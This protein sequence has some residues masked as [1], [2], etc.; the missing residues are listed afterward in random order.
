MTLPLVK[1]DSWVLDILVDPLDKSRLR[2]MEGYD[3]VWLSEYGRVY[4]AIDGV[5]DLRVL[6]TDTTQSA[7]IWRKGQAAYETW[8]A[9]MAVNDDYDTYIREIEGVREVYEAL[10]ITGVC[11][12]VGGHQGRVRYFLDDNVR[13]ISCDPY[14]N[15]LAHLDAQPNLL[16]AYPCLNEPCNFVCA[17]AEYLPFAAQSFDTLHM[18]SVLD[19]FASPEQALLETYRVLKADGFLVLG[20]AVRFGKRGTPSAMVLAKEFASHVLQALRIRRSADFH[21]WKPTYRMVVDLI[22]RCGFSIEQEHWQEGTNNRVIYLRARKMSPFPRLE[23]EPA[24]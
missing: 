9:E 12:D 21:T 23:T 6:Q 4:R 24:S 5:R 19:H 16:K 8:S 1:L 22:Q 14:L 18:R 10:P 7:R 17:Q 15:V 2:K 3:D 20:T 11:L 13:Y